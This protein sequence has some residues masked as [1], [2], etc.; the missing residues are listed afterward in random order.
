MRVGVHTSIAGSLTK[1]IDE[2][3]KLR[4]DTMQIFS[5]NPRG[6]TPKPLTKPE[7]KGFIAAREQAGI[8]PV[9]VHAVYLINLTAPDPEIRRKSIA[10]FRQEIN[11]ALMLQADFLVVHPG[12]VK[13]GSPERG[14]VE[15]IRSIKKATRGLK[16]RNLSILIENT[17]GQGGQI[18]RTFE[19]VAAI[20]SGLDGLPVGCCL[21]TAHTYAAGYDLSSPAGLSQTLSL[22]NSTVGLAHI[23]VIHANDTKVPLN[24][25]VDR[26]WHI[27]QGNIGLEGFRRLVNHPLL[28]HL[29]H[30]LETPKK[31]D[32]D[33]ARNIATL[34]QLAAV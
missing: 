15:C 3:S 13:A 34:R 17:A 33:D 9:V 14:I 31:T 25:A 5:R 7:A 27:G 26:H 2:A 20:L 23:N 8:S 4:C 1:A 22:I 19:Q 10:A 11:R 16:L 18:G 30:I 6:W 28:A 12:S 21:D 32:Q 24:G 29:P